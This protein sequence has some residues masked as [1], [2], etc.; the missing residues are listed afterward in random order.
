M[1]QALVEQLPMIAT[2]VAPNPEGYKEVLLAVIVRALAQVMHDTNPQVSLLPVTTAAHPHQ[3]RQSAAE[4]MASVAGLLK[5]QDLVRVCLL[6]SSRHLQEEHVMPTVRELAADENEEG[7][8]R[9]TVLRCYSHEGCPEFRVEAC[10]IFRTLA[11]QLGPDLNV[12]FVNS[13]LSKY[14]LLL[15]SWYWQLG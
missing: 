2:L 8:A 13:H 15:P 7:A 14:G 9:T 1:R 5:R 12:A 11:A 6:L 4:S 10:A 3:V